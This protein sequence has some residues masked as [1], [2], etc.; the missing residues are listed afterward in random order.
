MPRALRPDPAVT[1]A[2]RAE[3]ACSYWETIPLRTAVTVGV[4]QIA[5][6]AGALSAPV[7]LGGKTRMVALCGAFVLHPAIATCTWND[8]TWPGGIVKRAGAVPVR[9][10]AEPS[11]WPDESRNETPGKPYM[12]HGVVPALRRM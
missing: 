8:D 2:T 5:N 11:S 12:L 9:V 3:N 1:R 4:V 7:W 10:A 6:V